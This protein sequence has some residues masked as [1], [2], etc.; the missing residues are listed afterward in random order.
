MAKKEVV[1]GIEI[2]DDTPTVDPVSQV[3]DFRE[4]AASEAF[5]NEMVKSWCTLALTKTNLLM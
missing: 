2:I 4:L 5:M 1:A 3:V